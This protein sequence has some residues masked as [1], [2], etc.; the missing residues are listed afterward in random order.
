MKCDQECDQGSSG[1]IAGRGSLF[2]LRFEAWF[3][4]D[5]LRSEDVDEQI[6]AEE[7]K[8]NILSMLHQILTPFMLR[9]L[10]V[11]ALLGQKCRIETIRREM[12]ISL[13]SG[14]ILIEYFV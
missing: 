6:V 5:A 11:T 13:G 2:V 9:R 4:V 7:Q 12:I 8:K 14:L 1:S 10:K 3:D